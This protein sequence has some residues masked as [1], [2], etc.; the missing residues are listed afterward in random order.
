MV[1]QRTLATCVLALA[2]TATMLGCGSA[3]GPGSARSREPAGEQ[4]GQATTVLPGC[5]AV[6]L[7]PGRA[8]NAL[9]TD[10]LVHDAVTYQSRPGAEEGVNGGQVGARVFTVT[11]SFAQLNARTQSELPAPTEHSAGQ[12]PAGALVHAVKGWPVTCRLTAERNGRWV[13]YLA[14][15]PGATTMTYAPCALRR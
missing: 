7:T 6:V 5:P 14:T 2:V 11:C 13:T 8:V 9:V 10:F 1:V 3:V 15:V 12:L 4:A